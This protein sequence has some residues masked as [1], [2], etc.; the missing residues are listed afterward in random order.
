[1]SDTQQPYAAI[2]ETQVVDS[3][4][5]SGIPAVNMPSSKN[6]AENVMVK[7]YCI[8]TLYPIITRVK[9][10]RRL[11]EDEWLAIQRLRTLTHDGGQKYKGRSNVYMPTYATAHNALLTQISRGLFPSDDYMDI[12]A[13]DSDADDESQ[14]VKQ[15]LQYELDCNAKLRQRIKPALSQLVDHGMMVLKYW[16][17]TGKEFVGKKGKNKNGQQALPSFNAKPQ[18]GLV[19]SARSIFNVVVYPETAECEDDILVTAEYIDTDRN[20]ALALA[21]SNRWLNT[22]E[23]LAAGANVADISQ[24]S[25]DQSIMDQSKIPGMLENVD[26]SDERKPT[27]Q[28]ITIIECYV[29]MRLPP[30]AYVEG[31]DKDL[32]I[33]ARVVLVKGIPV[34]VTR[35]QNYDQKH[36]YLW[37]REGVIPGSF[38]GSWAGRRARHLQYLINDFANQTNDTGIYGLNPFMVVDTNLLTGPL[39]PLGPGRVFRTRDVKNAISFNHPPMEPIQYGQNLL[40]LYTS[41]LMDNTGAPPVMQGQKGADTATASSI[42]QRNSLSPLQDVIEDIEAQVMVPLLERAW[43]QIVQ[44]TDRP[45]M[46]VQPDGTQKEIQVSDLDQYEYN[47]KFL[48]SS[49]AENRSA[50]AQQAIQVL[51]QVVPNMQ[52]IQANG[53]MANPVEVFKKLWNDGFGWR[54]FDKFM[55]K[56]P[57]PMGQ[58]GMPG[59]P[60]QP[61]APGAPQ[62]MPGQPPGGPGAGPSP[63]AA[64]TLPQGPENNAPIPGNGPGETPPQAT[65][66]FSAMRTITDEINA[67]QNGRGGG[68]P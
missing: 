52:L 22:D 10:R 59:Q 6:F 36:P 58:P 56:V 9:N 55:F 57:P 24:Y 64:P 19:V 14:Q 26:G 39:L 35:N 13:M 49:Q 11:L 32:P 28:L 44:F 37:G 42:L 45:I 5:L 51:Q 53:Y 33:P 27:A 48:A 20:Y 66:D 29:S 3:S 17:R 15:I 2:A 50:R 43:R 1:M 25:R 68:Q 54:Q 47:F 16:Y 21:K 40:G 4:A 12:E 38:Y 65:D 18:K 8:T 31:E 23:A 7:D 60:G 67:M 34:E 46:V 41:A 61:G 62:G 30:E 63:Q